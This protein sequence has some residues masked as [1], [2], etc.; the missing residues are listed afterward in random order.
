MR[1]IFAY[2]QAAGVEPTVIDDTTHQNVTAAF[3]ET[4]VNVAGYNN[5]GTY[6]A[7]RFFS[8]PIIGG[9]SQPNT[10]TVTFS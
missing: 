2:P 8:T 6:A 1:V 3:Q 4:A 9:A 5:S 10:Y 7:Y